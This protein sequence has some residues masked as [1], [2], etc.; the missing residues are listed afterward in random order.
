[1][2]W[3]KVDDKGA[4]LG[5]AVFE[6]RLPGRDGE[7]RVEVA[8]NTGQDGYTGRDTDPAAGE[9]AVAGLDFG[10]WTLVETRAPEGYLRD[11]DSR[12]VVVDAHT[13]AVDAGVFV[14][15]AIWATVSGHKSVWELDAE[16]QPVES[17]GVVDYGDTVLYGIDVTAGGSVPQTGVTVTDPVPDGV[18]YVK[19]SADCEPGPCT[20]DYDA[21][22]ATLTWTVEQ[23]QP[24]AVVT[25]YFL[26]TVDAAPALPPGGS[27]HLRVDNIGSV[28]SDLA[29]STPTNM[30]RVEASATAP[31]VDKPPVDKPP[32]DK[33][34]VKKPPVDQ[35]QTPHGPT[36]VPPTAPQQHPQ[37][38]AV[39]P[40]PRQPLAHTGVEGLPQL[41]GGAALLLV[42][43]AGLW[44]VAG[45][46][47]V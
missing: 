38:P 22:T 12:Q 30:V 7:Q 44:R 39:T 29:P 18:S 23:M 33:P 6:L 24:G 25:V 40:T 20:V 19:G 21:K 31:P 42:I 10:T 5:G 36:P 43:G 32:V 13:G 35:P 47:E 46:R 26:A 27:A 1:M 15:V 17:D 34:P 11:G 28:S 2:T 3:T 37:T 14:N 45:R 4:R 8:D 9:F 41:L 16:G